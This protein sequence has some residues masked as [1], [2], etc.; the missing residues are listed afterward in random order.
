M[1]NFFASQ[2]A[3]LCILIRNAH[4]YVYCTYVSI[5]TSVYVCI[6]THLYIRIHTQIHR[7]DTNSQF[8]LV[9]FMMLLRKPRRASKNRVH[10]YIHTHART[11]T[12][13]QSYES[14]ANAAERSE[15][16]RWVTIS[17]PR[18]SFFLFPEEKSARF[19]DDDTDEKRARERKVKKRRVKYPILDIREQP[20]PGGGAGRYRGEQTEGSG[21]REWSPRDFKKE[22]SLIV[23]PLLLLLVSLLGRVRFAAWLLQKDAV[24]AFSPPSARS[25]PSHASRIYRGWCCAPKLCTRCWSIHRL[26]I[27]NPCPCPPC[28]C[29]NF[30]YA[31]V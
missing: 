9:R 16:D 13:A 28:R 23:F 1:Q 11:R 29:S 17:F 10:T 2:R 4:V 30:H 24:A 12:H 15:H 21:R 19:T 18:T 14:N 8:L 27:N 25:V 20:R 6:Y 22:I 5:Y 3:L 31:Y 26:K 7:Y